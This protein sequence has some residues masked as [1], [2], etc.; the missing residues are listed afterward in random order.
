TWSELAPVG[1]WGGIVTMGCHFEVKGQ[2]GTYRVLF[3]DDGRFIREGSKQT[4][5]IVFTLYSSTSTDGGLT[6]GQPETIFSSS[7]VNLCEPGVI[8]SPDG[9]RLAV[10][11][12]ENARRKN[13]HIIFSDD[14]GKTWTPPRELPISQTGDRH[15]GKYGPDGRLFI[16]FRGITPGMKTVRG[17]QESEGPMPTAGDWSGWV[18]TW[19]DLVNGTPGQY[20]V[21]VMDNKK[22]ADTTY[23]GVE[24]LPDGTFVLVTYGH[25]TA[26]EE[27]YIMCVRLR[28]DELDAKAERAAKI[29]L[30]ADFKTVVEVP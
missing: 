12:R 9:K 4:K 22:G 25:W 20:V 6:W 2:P 14:E 16:S 18:G 23:P 10:L 13:S 11:L 15:T 17:T 27:P 19:E 21:R 8:R 24:I 7:D 3:H 28:L 26:G 30:S 1:D 5:P 29:T